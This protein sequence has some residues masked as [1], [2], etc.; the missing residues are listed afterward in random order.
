MVFEVVVY[1]LDEGAVAARNGNR[2]IRIAARVLRQKRDQLPRLHVGRYCERETGAFGHGI[3]DGVSLYVV[4]GT[5]AE[6]Y[7]A[8]KLGAGKV[9]RLARRVFDRVRQKQ[10]I[11]PF[12]G[13]RAL[14]GAYIFRAAVQY[15]KIGGA[16]RLV[17]QNA[18]ERARGGGKFFSRGG[19]EELSFG[20]VKKDVYPRFLID[21]LYAFFQFGI[22]FFLQERKAALLFGLL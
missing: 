22:H 14:D 2:R 16:E 4:G 10:R 20:G 11:I 7:A 1:E 3:F 6:Q 9:E 12:H 18:A 21:G 8:H 13:A 19:K 17:L 15:L 5:F